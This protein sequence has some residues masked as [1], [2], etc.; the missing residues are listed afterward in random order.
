MGAGRVDPHSVVAGQLGL[1]EVKIR[2]RA[3]INTVHSSTTPDPG[4]QWEKQEPRGRPFP[5]R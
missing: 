2:K 5:S 1:A 3:K 4:Y